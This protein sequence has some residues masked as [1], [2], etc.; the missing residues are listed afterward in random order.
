MILNERD[1]RQAHLIE[2]AKQ[3][4]TAARTA[5]KGRGVDLIETAAITGN[6]LVDLSKMMIEMGK[7][8]GMDFFVRDANCILQAETVVLLGTKE[9]NRGLNCG[10]CGY[11]S[12]T[13]KPAT[14]KCAFNTLDL[15]IAIGSACAMAADLRIDNRVMF[16]AGIAARR[17]KILGDC[18]CVFA[19]PLSAG[20]KNPFFDRK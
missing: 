16:S 7:K 3:M 8:N 4:M 10:Y 12:C 13:D 2:A 6:D 19:I 18:D 9:E 11:P 15:G 17:L 1:T 20:S 14:A 5:P